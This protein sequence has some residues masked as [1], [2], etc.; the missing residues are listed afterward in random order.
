[1]GFLRLPNRFDPELAAF[2]ATIAQSFKRDFSNLRRHRNI[3]E[4]V[5]DFDFSDIRCLQTPSLSGQRS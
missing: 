5:V 1:V 4:V 2:D 3:T